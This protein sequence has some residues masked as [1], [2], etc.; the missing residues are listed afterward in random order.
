MSVS[1]KKLLIN[2]EEVLCSVFLVSM[3]LLVIVNVI[4]RY[5]FNYSIFWAEEVATICFVWCVFI[6]A[7]ATYKNKMDIGI[8]VLIS[9]TPPKVEATIRFAVLLIL[10]VLNGYIFYMAMVFTNIAWLKPTAVLGISSAIFNSALIVGFGLITL[11][12][13]KFIY[14]DVTKHLGSEQ[15]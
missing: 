12:T 1:I 6:G 14:L 13:I 5:L 11:H 8:D 3:I 2:L 10:L 7:S 9:R 15:A 4:L